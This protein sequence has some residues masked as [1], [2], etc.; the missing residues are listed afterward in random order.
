MILQEKMKILLLKNENF[1]TGPA[2][3]HG[4]LPPGAFTLL[5]YIYCIPY[6]KTHV[7]F[8]CFS[9]THE[10]CTKTH[11]FCTE[12]HEFQLLA[13]ASW[14]AEFGNPDTDDWKNFLH[15]YS[16]YVFRCCSALYIHAGD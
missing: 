1:R 7:S 10:F 8:T 13:G 3:G 12:N 16:P 4:A 11:E 2:A 14:M 5:F 6:V 9:K 15:K